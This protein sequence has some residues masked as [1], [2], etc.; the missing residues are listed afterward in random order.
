MKERI[1]VCVA[2]YRDNQLEKTIISLLKNAEHP[3]LID[4]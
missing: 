4:V 2:S 3:E 1:F